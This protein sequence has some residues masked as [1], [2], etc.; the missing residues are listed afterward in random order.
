[1]CNNITF[2]GQFIGTEFSP[3]NRLGE[4]IGYHLLKTKHRKI[5][6]HLVK[7]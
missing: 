1:M 5:S 6:F 7:D 3:P 4:Q 2:A